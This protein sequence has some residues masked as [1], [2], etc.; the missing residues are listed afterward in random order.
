MKTDLNITTTNNG[1]K[2]TSKLSYVNPLAFAAEL[3]TL[4]NKFAALS[5]DTLTAATRTDTTDIDLGSEYTPVNV[6]IF[7][8][9]ST[10]S[11]YETTLKYSDVFDNGAV[12]KLVV[13]DT[14]E[15]LREQLPIFYDCL[16]PVIKNETRFPV[17]F[18]RDTYDEEWPYVLIII[19]KSDDIGTIDD[20]GG[21]LPA[22]YVPPL[23]G[24]ITIST[25]TIK[26]NYKNI[27]PDIQIKIKER[28]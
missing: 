7:N 2:K 28:I 12:I 26:G 4:A 23:T 18:M 6:E 17:S 22:I 8:E 19:G 11:Q 24:A 16:E 27:A 9:E 14:N 20:D 13:T 1:T 25:K 3:A 10:S 21:E 15:E 5:D